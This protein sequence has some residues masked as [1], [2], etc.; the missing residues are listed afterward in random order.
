MDEETKKEITRLLLQQVEI[1]KE[2]GMAEEKKPESYF[3]VLEIDRSD[4]WLEDASEE[5]K[6]FFKGKEDMFKSM[7][8]HFLMKH[9]PNVLALFAGVPELGGDIL[10]LQQLFFYVGYLKGLEQGEGRGKKSKEIEG[11]EKLMGE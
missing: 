11:L 5:I 8:I 3:E 2:V 9:S 6:N 7:T 10:D 4:K 1:D